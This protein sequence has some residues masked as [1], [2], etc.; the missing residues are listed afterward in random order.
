MEER[1]I[2][3]YPRWSRAR[4][5]LLDDPRYT[6]VASTYQKEQWFNEYMAAQAPSVSLVCAFFFI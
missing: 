6:E 2:E 5:K 3:K 4:E 1:R